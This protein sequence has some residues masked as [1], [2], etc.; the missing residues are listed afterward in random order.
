VVQV[1]HRRYPSPR[2]KR[3]AFDGHYLLDGLNEV[4]DQERT[5]TLAEAVIDQWARPLEF[6]NREQVVFPEDN[7]HSHVGE[8][9][10]S[11]CQD[12][13]KVAEFS[14]T[15]RYCLTHNAEYQRDYYR[16]KKSRRI[17]DGKATVEKMLN[18]AKHPKRK[19]LVKKTA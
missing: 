4:I 2:Q 3:H 9:W 17:H 11:K 1:E 5:G 12:W 8:R 19:P 7:A 6:V 15:M 13:L 14:G 16:N 10:C 18:K